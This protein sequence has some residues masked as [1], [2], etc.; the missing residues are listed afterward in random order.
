[1]FSNILLAVDGSDP[2]LRAAKVAGEM[3]RELGSTLWVVV[4]YDPIPSYLG[5]PN[6]QQALNERLQYT[7]DIMAPALA[8]IGDVP[9][10]I[11]KE[12]LEG[13]PAEAVLNVMQAREIDLIIMG[14]RG[15]G[16]L[17][18]LLLGSQSHKV[19]THANCPVMLVR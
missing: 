3:A 16:Q 17:T 9:G 8:A 1:M 7:A 15:R 13:P 10:E 12:T 5:E 4:C 2:S 11:H 19:V 14:T 6:L 18:G